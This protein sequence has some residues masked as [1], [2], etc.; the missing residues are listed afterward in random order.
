MSKQGWDGENWVYVNFGNLWNIFRKFDSFSIFILSPS[1]VVIR[2]WI[3]QGSL[4][5]DWNIFK[6]WLT[7]A[8]L[9]W[10]RSRGVYLGIVRVRIIK[11]VGWPNLPS[12]GPSTDSTWTREPQRSWCWCEAKGEMRVLD[13]VSPAPPHHQHSRPP[14]RDSAQL[15]S[16]I[17]SGLLLSLVRI[18]DS[19]CQT[20]TLNCNWRWC[21]GSLNRLWFSNFRWE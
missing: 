4:F 8:R 7:V 6:N 5:L 3:I 19:P 1:E 13:I 14:I 15:L 10:H 16:E 12:P 17:W 11:F 20:G 21:W 2:Q 9:L 18:H